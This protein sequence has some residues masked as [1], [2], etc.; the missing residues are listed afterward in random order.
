[1]QCSVDD[2]GAWSQDMAGEIK[3]KL[4]IYWLLFE[5]IQLIST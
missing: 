4:K 3:A 1:M 2:T 5:G